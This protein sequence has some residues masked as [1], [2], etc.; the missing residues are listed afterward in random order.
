MHS[1]SMC[2]CIVFYCVLKLRYDGTSVEE[3][4]IPDRVGCSTPLQ[5]HP[6]QVGLGKSLYQS[7]IILSC[8]DF[9][10]T[11]NTLRSSWIK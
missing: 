6:V 10:R 7:Y 4:Q 5:E 1:C 9:G 3:W 8:V 2:N 11:P